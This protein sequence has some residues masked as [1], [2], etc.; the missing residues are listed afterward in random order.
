MQI[1]L[2]NANVSEI[3][4][5]RN[6]EYRV[7]NIRLKNI[8]VYK[9]RWVNFTIFYVYTEINNNFF[10]S[11]SIENRK[12]YKLENNIFRKLFKFKIFINRVLK[13]I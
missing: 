10:V 3:L 5:F 1:F 11:I 7:K 13:K 8:R 9:N 6:S 12:Q 2:K 4:A